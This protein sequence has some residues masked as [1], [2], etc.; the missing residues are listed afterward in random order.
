MEY[1]SWEDAVSWLVNQPDKQELVRACYYD[2]PLKSAA[3]R[4]WYSQEWQAI[5]DF[6]PTPLGN[7]LDLGAGNGIA[8][9][10]LARDGWKVSA[11][12]PNPSELVGGGA[13]QQL[14]QEVQ[15]PIKVVQGFGEQLPFNDG[16]F[17]IVFAR[18]V[19]HHA[20]NLRQLCSEIYRVLKPGGVLVAVREHVIS[21]PHDLTK[22]LDAHPLHK[23]Y[24][25]EHAYRLEEYLKA[26]KSAG[27]RVK[28]VI[29]P[30]DSIIN[31][32]PKTDNSLQDEL[33]KR[34]NSIPGGGILQSLF[35]N[36]R[37]FKLFLSL[38]SKVDNRPGRVFSFVSCKQER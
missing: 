23:L 22:F 12:E 11:L 33:K 38:L 14:A 36:K 9:Y 8:S 26:M 35:L 7:A 37:T 34:F 1:I 6:F 15:L 28:K 19:L 30:F 3:E 29:G 17:D 25:G 21:S 5:R 24:G 13:I 18:Q 4:Y 16:I 2:R 32:A 31:Y 20:Q 10:A 27:F